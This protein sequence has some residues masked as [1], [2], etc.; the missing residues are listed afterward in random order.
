MGERSTSARQS[1]EQATSPLYD[2]HGA[3]A[4]LHHGEQFVRHLVARRQ[5]RAARV[6]RGKLL[7]KQRWLDE[8]IERAADNQTKGP[9]LADREP[10]TASVDELQPA[11]NGERVA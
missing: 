9:R 11:R 1:P 2:V 10:R 4:Y 7:F 3:G 6:G 8:Y 5:L